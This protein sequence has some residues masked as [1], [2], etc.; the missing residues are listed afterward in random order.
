MK[1]KNRILSVLA[2]LAL[3]F[4]T[5]GCA[6]LLGGGVPMNQKISTSVRAVAPQCDVLYIRVKS[7]SADRVEADVDLY[8][9]ESGGAQSVSVTLAKSPQGGGLELTRESEAAILAATKTAATTAQTPPAAKTGE[10]EKIR[11][12]RAADASLSPA[13]L[14]EA[15]ER[16]DKE[17]VFAALD[18]GI[19]PNKK[20]TQTSLRAGNPN[21]ERVVDADDTPL[22][23]AVK[24][25]NAE[26]AKILLDAGAEANK[27]IWHNENGFLLTRTAVF[28]A[29]EKD[30]AAMIR[31]LARHGADVNFRQT[32][33]WQAY[34]VCNV[35]AS[36]TQ[37]PLGIAV[38]GKK[39]EAVKA[40]LAAGANPNDEFWDYVR[41]DYTRRNPPVSILAMACSD[42]NDLSMLKLLADA[43]ADVNYVFP[44][45]GSR[46]GTVL[47]FTKDPVMREYL[48]SKGARS[49]SAG[50]TRYR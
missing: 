35:P 5:P 32:A 13:A 50:T 37:T 21:K 27:K 17:G 3:A 12:K 48:E 30:D 24:A 43:G 26:I 16:G 45:G 15:T 22:S 31:L 44:G 20:R 14:F 19:D 49:A 8:S 2:A 25:G 1:T 46:T 41:Q 28:F 11:V 4:A 34:S 6:G 38:A 7:S 39:K 40:L 36:G 33:V 10:P 18:S 9:P 29:A 47:D 42:E 23:L